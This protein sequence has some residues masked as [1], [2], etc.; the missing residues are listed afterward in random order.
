MLSPWT[1]SSGSNNNRISLF[2]DV[3]TFTVGTKSGD[4]IAYTFEMGTASADSPAIRVLIGL[5]EESSQEDYL[6]WFDSRS[7]VVY[8]RSEI[9]TPGQKTSALTLSLTSGM[10]ELHIYEIEGSEIYAVPYQSVLTPGF[11]DLILAKDPEALFVQYLFFTRDFW[12]YAPEGKVGV[13]AYINT[14]QVPIIKGYF[15]IINLSSDAA[16]CIPTTYTGG[17]NNT[18]FGPDDLLRS[19]WTAPGSPGPKVLSTGCSTS[20]RGDPHGINGLCCQEVIGGCCGNPDL[21]PCSLLGIAR[22]PAIDP[23]TN[24]IRTVTATDNSGPKRNF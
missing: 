20:S 10:G 14:F 12:Q 3:S 6:D 16:G 18:P 17:I 22:C 24:V 9:L 2:P 1:Y 23:N 11:I 8:N 21:P 19:S 13:S 15:G 4:G 7:I 5:G